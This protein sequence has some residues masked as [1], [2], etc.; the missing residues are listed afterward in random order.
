[1]SIFVA[2][3]SSGCGASERAEPTKTSHFS[4][5]QKFPVSQCF[6]GITGVRFK[7]ELTYSLGPSLNKS[8]IF[9]YG[10]HEA[11]E[12]DRAEDAARQAEV[13]EDIGEFRVD[14]A[15]E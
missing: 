1:M 10:P 3:V 4:I 5:I 11:L 12:T 6:D 9:S 8:V 13:T 2:R 15:F 14:F 7:A